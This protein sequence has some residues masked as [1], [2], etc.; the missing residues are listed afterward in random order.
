M[1]KLLLQRIDTCAEQSSN[2][3]MLQQFGHIFVFD[4]FL[5]GILFHK[6]V[7]R[8]N[9]CRY[10]LTLVGNNSYLID[11]TVDNQ[12]GFQCLRSDVFSVRCLKQVFDTLCQIQLPIFKIAGITGMKPTFFIDSCSRRF[13]L[14]II[15]FRD[16]L[17]TKQNLV[18]FADLHFYLRHHLTYRTNIITRLRSTR[19]SCRRFCQTIS[20]QHIDTHRMYKLANFIGNSS[21]GCRE[22]VTVLYSDGLFQQ[23]IDSLLIKLIFQLNHSGRRLT[24][25]QIIQIMDTAYFNSIQHQH[26]FYSGGLG[27]FFLNAGVHFLPKTRDTTHQCR[28]DFFNGCLDIG[29]TKIDADLYALMHTEI[30]PCLLKHMGQRQEVHRNIL[31]GHIYQTDIMN[32]ECFQIARMMQHD[33][34]RFARSTGR[35]QDVCQILSTGTCRTFFHYFIVWQ[36]FSFSQELVIVNRTH[37]TR[38]FH[39]RRIKNDQ[40]Y[41]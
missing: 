4:A 30:S 41:K 23:S 40:L 3:R 7:Y 6:T 32:T 33:S 1:G 29:R 12:F 16:G 13:R 19:N 26:F 35:I 38:I 8:Y 28:T 9:Q 31:I 11:I 14:F 37:I 25:P 5:F 27:Y 18:I 22:E 34:F 15:P 2:F 21:T 20:N 39:Y 17:S 10:K 36:I 24:H